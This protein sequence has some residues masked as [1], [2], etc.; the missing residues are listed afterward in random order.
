MVRSRFR[1][2][3]LLSLF[4]LL[5]IHSMTVYANGPSWELHLESENPGFRNPDERIVEINSRFNDFY[6]TDSLPDPSVLTVMTW[7]IKYFGG[8]ASDD[9]QVGNVIEVLKRIKPD[10]V[11]IQE[12]VSDDVL[13][14]IVAEIPAY[15]ALYATYITQ[16]Q[17]L[18]FLF[19][20]EVLKVVIATSI[21]QVDSTLRADAN[22]LD[23]LKYYAAGRLPY[24]VKFDL[25]KG[26][27][28][29][30]LSTINIHAKANTGDR[31]QSYYRRSNMANVL[32]ETILRN[33]DTWEH[34]ILLG[35]YNDDLD[36]SIYN[37]LSTPY[38]SFLTN[39][40]YFWPVT[41]PLT[42]SGLT[43]MPSY[44]DVIDHIIAT[45]SMEDFSFI[46]EGDVSVH[47]PDSYI[48]NYESTTS[49]HYPV[50]ASFTLST[51]TSLHQEGTL[52]KSF[53]LDPAYPNP[54]NPSTTLS[55][56]LKESEFVE[57]TVADITGRQ[58][59]LLA[60][61]NFS[62]GEHRLFFDASEL[63]TGVYYIQY[64]GLTFLNTQIVT[65]I[66]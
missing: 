55:F 29:G 43:S 39:E 61:Q 20:K 2:V 52:V 7:N 40:T 33:E 1:L 64:R 44:N 60:S 21:D 59:G 48:Q 22:L 5:M 26:N 66:R 14:E 18:A 65:L 24:F 35:D 32:Y 15:G 23:D 41:F 57:I 58:L 17:K 46:R 54:F 63:A 6:S 3:Y 30:S 49:D 53:T 11:A 12:I 16:S 56:T 62:A 31:Q 10:I 38:L 45:R 8:S 4:I 51:N 9:R 19:N 27:T 42:T 25:S 36:V 47:R 37:E 50:V 28:I 34:S 13:D